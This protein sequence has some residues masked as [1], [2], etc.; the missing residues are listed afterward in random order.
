MIN[1]DKP[2]VARV[3]RHSSFLYVSA[4]FP[5]RERRTRA[6]SGAS[7]VQPGGVPGWALNSRVIQGGFSKIGMESP[8]NSN[9]IDDF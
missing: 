7:S 5:F 9:K 8:W 2:L 6:S 3:P 1:D 4:Q